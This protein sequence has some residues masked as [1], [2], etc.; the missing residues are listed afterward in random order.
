MKLSCSNIQ[1]FL[2]FSQKKAFLI[3]WDTKTLKNSLYLSKRN[4]LIFQE[5]ET[6]KKTSYIA[7]N[8][9]PSSKN[10]KKKTF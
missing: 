6:L 4:A 1:I 5:T 9:F 8:N 3:F 10:E 7:G 2:I